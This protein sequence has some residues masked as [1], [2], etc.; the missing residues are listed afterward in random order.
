MKKINDYLVANIG[1]ILIIFI[2]DY[3][4]F[5]K[6]Q[7]IQTTIT[8]PEIKI[9]EIRCTYQPMG[10][11]AMKLQDCSL[12]TNYDEPCPVIDTIWCR[13]DVCQK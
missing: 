4:I 12:A 1:I 10:E 7:P 8:I 5:F 2:I 9:P 13:G 3:I 6:N 11:Y